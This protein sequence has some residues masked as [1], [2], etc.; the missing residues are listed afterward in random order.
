VTSKKD[1]AEKNISKD[2]MEDEDLKTLH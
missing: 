1:N 2:K